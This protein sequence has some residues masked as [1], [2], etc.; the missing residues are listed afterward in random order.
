[1][2]VQSYF[3]CGADVKCLA[4]DK[5][6][7]VL[8]LLS[9]QRDSASTAYSFLG[10]VSVTALI[11]HPESTRRPLSSSFLGLPYRIPN[12]SHKQELLRGLWVSPPW[13][14]E[15]AT[16]VGCR[17]SHSREGAEGGAPFELTVKSL[18]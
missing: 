13:R 16:G 17:Q 15:A 11:P 5:D 14:V 2:P 10:R 9:T 7:E 6:L 8:E 3:L 1:M 18:A 12:I 4:V